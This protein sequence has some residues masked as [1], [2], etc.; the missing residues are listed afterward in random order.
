MLN[1]HLRLPEIPSPRELS[2][3]ELID[4]IRQVLA[5]AKEQ[6]EA[7]KAGPEAKPEPA[8]EPS[9]PEPTAAPVEDAQL[10]EPVKA[11]SGKKKDDS[12][13]GGLF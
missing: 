9:T 2:D 3:A 10:D 7:E 5:L 4:G 6:V 12:P 11:V 1:K 8:P 13:Q